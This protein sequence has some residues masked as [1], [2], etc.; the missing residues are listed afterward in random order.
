[1]YHII[2]HHGQIIFVPTFLGYGDSF[3][4]I[5][6]SYRLGQTTVRETVYE[7]CDKIWKTPARMVMPAPTMKQWQKIEEG[8]SLSWNYP[9]Y[10][11]AIDG[12]HVVCEKTTKHST[13]V[14]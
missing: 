10:L 11:G 2:L 3:A 13:P 12:K 1:M 8:F 14:L 4:T 6:F 9:N 7:T 5:P